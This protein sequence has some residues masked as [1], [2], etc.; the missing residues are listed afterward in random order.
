LKDL[1]DIFPDLPWPAKRVTPLAA[2][3]RA[4][5]RQAE[6]ARRRMESSV[7]QRRRLAARVR[8]AWRYNVAERMKRRFK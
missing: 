6:Q 5:Q 8:Q 7:E 3:V 4:V 1:F 2:R